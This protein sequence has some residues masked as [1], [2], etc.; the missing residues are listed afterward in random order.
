M[1]AFW[2]IQN[3]L[4]IHV[5]EPPEDRWHVRVVAAWMGLTEDQVVERF[6]GPSVPKAAAG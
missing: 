1:E 3:V 5:P 4:S 2:Q 6:G